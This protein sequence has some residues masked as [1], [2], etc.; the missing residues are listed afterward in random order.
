MWIP[1]LPLRCPPSFWSLGR[2]ENSGLLCRHLRLSCAFQG[3]G[4]DLTPSMPWAGKSSRIE[5]ISE[6]IVPC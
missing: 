3:L 1:G 5:K 4:K 6:T 2:P